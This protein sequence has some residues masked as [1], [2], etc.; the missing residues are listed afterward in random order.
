[1]NTKS[2]ATLLLLALTCLAA[3]GSPAAPPPSPR[4]PFPAAGEQLSIDVHEGTS[5]AVSV[6]PDGQWLALDL[7]GSLWRLPAGGGHARRITDYFMDARQPVWTPDGKRLIFFAYRDGGY[8]LWSVAPD[9]ADIRK[10]T[11]GAYDDRDPAISPDGSFVAFASDRAGLGAP[12]YHIWTL[13]LAT[14][15]LRQV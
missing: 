14:G 6:S 8:H 5:M 3:H 15:L 4:D 13:E 11:A 2:H 12:S 10:L 1:M 9:G 7:Q